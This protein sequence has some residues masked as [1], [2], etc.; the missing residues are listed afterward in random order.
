MSIDTAWL[1]KNI[2][3][4]ALSANEKQALS[5]VNTTTVAKG[6]KIITEGQPGGTLEIMYSGR[7]KVEDNNRYEGRIT[8]AEI[9]AGTLF[10][11]LTFLNKKRR[12]ADVTALEDCVVYTLTQDDFTSLMQNQHELAYA[13]LAAIMERQTSVIMSQRVTLAPLLR[14]LKDKAKKLPLF[15][16]LAPVIFILLYIS[17]FLYISWKDFDYGADVE[18]QKSIYQSPTSANKP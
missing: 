9:E 14:T 12:T 2:L 6:E 7:A 17:G 13:I 11:E 16:K 8:L 5:C 15:I 10:G 18:Q 3:N 4:R 1:E